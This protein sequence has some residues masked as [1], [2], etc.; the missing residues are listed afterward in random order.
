[1]ECPICYE[2]LLECD[3][4]KTICG[5]NF[6]TSCLIR[7]AISCPSCPCCRKNLIQE[8]MQ[9][10][11][12]QEQQTQAQEQLIQEEQLTQE[13]IQRREQERQRYL[14]RRLQTIQEQC[15][16]YMNFFDVKDDDEEKQE[17][18]LR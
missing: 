3:V 14:T 15:H 12:M 8:Q 16:I 9:E 2:V 10:Q 11:Q 17:Y 13:Q 5:H 7:H 6:H 1:M 18:V 4:A